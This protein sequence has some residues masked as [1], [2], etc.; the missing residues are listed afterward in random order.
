[1]SIVD[2]TLGGLTAQAW[3]LE[4]ARAHATGS[5]LVDQTVSAGLV[6]RLW[7]PVGSMPTVSE[8]LAG[9]PGGR[10]MSWFRSLSVADRCALDAQAVHRAEALADE[11]VELRG[12]ATGMNG[13]GVTRRRV[14][15]WITRRDDLECVA[16]LVRLH[17]L[18]SDRL[19]EVLARIDCAAEACLALFE[20]VGL[21]GD[22]RLRAASWCDPAHWWTN[23]VAGA[24]SRPG[25]VAGV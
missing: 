3:L 14:H 24:M 7:F 25:G 16:Y 1:M 6:A 23:L 8:I 5:E 21:A 9:S 19:H 18:P 20:C 10:A 13:V 17:P 15:D 22:E 4:Q 11:L 2:D 12:P